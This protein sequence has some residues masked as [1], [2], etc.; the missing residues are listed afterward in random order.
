[1]SGNSSILRS[2]NP[3]N[4]NTIAPE[5]DLDIV[6]DALASLPLN[7]EL[8][9]AGLSMQ[10]SVDSAIASYVETADHSVGIF[11]DN[12]VRSWGTSARASCFSSD[13]LVVRWLLTMHGVSVDDKVSLHE[14]Q[15]CILR[16]LINGDCFRNAHTNSSLSRGSRI[17]IVC[18]HL[19]SP[20]PSATDMS[21]AFVRRIVD[22]ISGDQK[23]TTPKISALASAFQ[24][25]SYSL[26][27]FSSPNH[28]KQDALRL[29]KRSLSSHTSDGTQVLPSDL[30]KMSKSEL[31]SFARS[32]L[33]PFQRRTSVADL[34]ELVLHH[35]LSADCLQHVNTS[36]WDSSPLGCARAVKVYLSS[37]QVPDSA[38]FIVLALS[39]CAQTM[40]LKP[41]RRVLNH[42]DVP[43][44]S[45]DLL[46]QLH[47][48]LKLYVSRMQKARSESDL[49]WKKLF[50]DLV[51][52]REN[53]P[54]LVSSSMKDRI[55]EHFLRLTGSVALKNG[56]C[57]ACAELCQD[58]SLHL[59]KASTIDLNLLRQPDAF[60]NDD[61]FVQPWL[62]PRVTSPVFLFAD[63]PLAG[64]LVHPKGVSGQ[65]I[66]TELALC[67]DCL[68]CLHRGHVPDLALSN[69]L[70]LGEVPPELKDLTVVEESM[71]ALCQAK[72]CI[73]HLKADGKE[74]ASHSVQRGVKGNLIIYPQQPSEIAKKLPPS[75]EDITSP[76]CVLF[77]GAHPPSEEWLRDKAKPLAVRGNKVR[78]ALLWLKRHNSLYKDVEIDEDVLLRLDSDPVL[79]FVKHLFSLHDKCFQEHYSFLFTAFNILQ[80]RNMLLRVGLKAKKKNFHYLASKFGQISSVAIHAVT[81]RVANGNS[82]VA[83]TPE[84]LQ[85]LKLMKQVNAVSSHIQGSS[86]SK[87]V[88]RSELKALMID[89][90]LPSFYLTINPSDVHNP[91]VRFLVG[92]DINVDTVLPSEYD[93]FAQSMLVSKNPFATAKFFNLYMCSFIRAVMGYDPKHCDPDGGIFGKVKAYYGCVKAQ[94]R[95]TLHCHMLVWVEGSMSPDEIKQCVMENDDEFQHRLIS[96]LDDTISNYMLADAD[97]DVPTY[98]PSS[99]WTAPVPSDAED[100]DPYLQKDRHLLV[101]RCQYHRYSA[102]CYKYDIKSCRFD[103]DEGNYRPV[104][105][106][107]LETGE[108]T[109]RCLHGLVN[110]FNETIL[111]CIQCNMDI[112]FVGS[113]ASAKA[114]LYY[115]TDYIT[116]SQLKT[117][118]AHAALELAILRLGDYD[119][120]KDEITY[121]AKRMLQRCAYTMIS[122]Q[123]LSVPQIISY[124]MDYGDHFTSHTYAPF[125][126]I[127]AEKYVDKIAPLDGTDQSDVATENDAVNAE[128]SMVGR[129]TEDRMQTNAEENEGDYDTIV[130]SIPTIDDDVCSNASD[131]CSEDRN[132]NLTDKDVEPDPG[133]GPS[134]S[135][136]DAEEEVILHIDNA[137]NLV[138]RSSLLDNYLCRGEEL[139]DVCLWDYIS[140][141][142]KVLKTKDRRKHRSTGSRAESED[143]DL[144]DNISDDD[145]DRQDSESDDD[146]PNDYGVQSLWDLHLH[147]NKHLKSTK[148]NRPR[149]EFALSHPDNKTHYQSPYPFK[150]FGTCPCRTVHPSV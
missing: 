121:H 96:F 31:Q 40:S 82:V 107:D 81:E 124:L 108:L 83:D 57:A 56:V 11:Y 65:G 78:Q 87:A 71:I 132:E 77:V 30:E 38:S 2:G 21:L 46:N 103:M 1:M 126:W 135:Q 48:C 74:Y 23:L 51:D 41:L 42:L 72:C 118:V 28:I 85:V 84:E 102:T 112:K 136:I 10:S 13:P 109:L 110:N 16:H 45:D 34:R 98:H 18:G 43:F 125:P 54:Q 68:G 138:S 61:P 80:R 95:G 52:T 111:D 32:H 55:R 50:D 137:D 114:I 39:Q 129:E 3:V 90:G 145:T 117:H 66:E 36:D 89:Q 19:S 113:G 53:W 4:V 5:P 6:L 17:D 20:F 25:P 116:K 79:P 22:D 93:S 104:S 119:P 88:Q 73:V 15:Y 47:K 148:R 94:G 100:V 33:I 76:I 8:T 143:G 122:H 144:S 69:H 131:A 26:D 7:A 141:I 14:M 123:E 70:F 86:A 35:V 62:D 59:V 105:C 60:K 120:S 64:V 106:F 115:I 130:E 92:S 146:E 97:V 12:I 58:Q 44:D 147:A 9:L 133:F 101:Q 29:F 139:R 27:A 127:G 140:R 63:G 134:V 128:S 75:I 150:S 99:V 37:G 24:N 91:L 149:L 142:E 67:N 49:S